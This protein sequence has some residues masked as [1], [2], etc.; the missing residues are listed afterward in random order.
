MRIIA[1]PK[2]NG[3]HRGRPIS[4]IAASAANRYSPW[5]CFEPGN[6]HLEFKLH[7]T[8]DL[9]SRLDFGALTRHERAKRGLVT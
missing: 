7:V 1:S 9:L 4:V 5:L 8:F 3:R 2:P 6:R